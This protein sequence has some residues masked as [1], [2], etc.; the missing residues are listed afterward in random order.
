MLFIE[1]LSKLVFHLVLL[2]IFAPRLPMHDDRHMG[3]PLVW[4]LAV[5]SDLLTRDL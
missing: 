3:Y 1:R 5:I 2:P 4:P